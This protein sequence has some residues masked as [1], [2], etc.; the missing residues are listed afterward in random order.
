M[1]GKTL[2]Q[3]E[4]NHPVKKKK[5]PGRRAREKVRPSPLPGAHGEGSGPMD[6]TPKERGE[7]LYSGKFPG[8]EER[9]RREKKF[10][11]WGGKTTEG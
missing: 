6:V 2:P 7:A 1:G 9:Y 3:D 5:V 10:S 4:K 11:L 8:R